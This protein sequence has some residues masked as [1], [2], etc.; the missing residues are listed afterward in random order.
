MTEKSQTEKSQDKAR[1]QAQEQENEVHAQQAPD[2][3]QPGVTTANQ[4]WEGYRAETPGAQDQP[5]AT[6]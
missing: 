4:D 3:E 5:T 2:A 6:E 1:K